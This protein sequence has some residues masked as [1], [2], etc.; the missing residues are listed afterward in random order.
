[1]KLLSTLLLLRACYSF[2]LQ[3]TLSGLSSSRSVALMAAVELE[4]E[5]EGGEEMTP[6]TTMPGCRMKQ[7]G[8]AEGK[9]SD[10][11]TVYN[12]WMTA[13]VDGALIKEYRTELLKNAKKK[14][15]FPGFRKVR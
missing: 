5:P 6:Q 10:D 2:V 8:E 9:K 11:G 13:E 4:T 12:F 14:A 15:N 3:P 1:M 7:M